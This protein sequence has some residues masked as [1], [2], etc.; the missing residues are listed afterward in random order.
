MPYPV[1]CLLDP[2]RLPWRDISNLMSNRGERFAVVYQQEDL[3]LDEVLV[4]NEWVYG[5]GDSPGC[6]D[7][8][9]D[10]LGNTYQGINQPVIAWLW[11][12][13]TLAQL[14]FWSIQCWLYHPESHQRFLD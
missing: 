7:K 14:M 12:P 6:M 3:A 2:R 4:R 10:R 11:Q 1:G 13:P 9:R 8:D 5:Q